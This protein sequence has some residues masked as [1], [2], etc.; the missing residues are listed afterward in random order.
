[1]HTPKTVFLIGFLISCISLILINGVGLGQDSSTQLLTELSN[2][3]Y[4]PF[5]NKPPP[6]DYR[7]SLMESEPNEEPE[8]AI[9][10]GIFPPNSTYTGHHSW[11]KDRDVFPVCL[12]ISGRLT[13]NLSLDSKM[14]TSNN[15]ELSFL[16]ANAPSSET[17]HKLSSPYTLDLGHIDAG[18]HYVLVYTTNPNGITAP[19]QLKIDF[20]PDPTPTPTPS[21]TPTLTP[22]NTPTLTPSATPTST[23]S[24]II[25]FEEDFDEML[26]SDKWVMHIS[27]TATIEAK[28]QDYVRLS[29]SDG[30]QTH[31]PYIYPQDFDFFSVTGEFY[32]QLQYRYADPS[33]KGV[34]F[35][36]IDPASNLPEYGFAHGISNAFAGIFQSSVHTGTRDIILNKTIV[37]Q[38][39]GSGHT[40]SPWRILTLHRSAD[41]L[42]TIYIDGAELASEIILP[43]SSEPN[44]FWI[45]NPVKAGPDG[46]EWPKLDLRHLCISDSPCVP[47]SIPFVTATPTHTPTPTLTPTPHPTLTSAEIG[48]IQRF[49]GCWDNYNDDSVAPYIEFREEDNFVLISEPNTCSTT[50]LERKA[51]VER[52]PEG[53]DDRI[54]SD[55]WEFEWNSD[56]NLKLF[57][58]IAPGAVENL[59]P[60]ETM[61]KER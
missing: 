41:S 12:P 60:Q 38:V 4:L 33:E 45:G 6:C 28:D 18:T 49:I 32:L 34:G 25:Y 8:E 51:S 11:V 26:S 7:N 16:H 19:Y 54:I 37:N 58:K 23:P 2:R 10:N 50:G 14:Q 21:N 13:I 61:R 3:I 40:G 57:I 48:E 35:A 39:F 15:I 55:T 46:D 59:V 56:G 42:Y 30:T 31:Y 22:S 17:L 9:Q 20:D 47:D 1:M 27:D 29:T 5:I 52:D 44:E 43:S 36:I 24:S 53:D